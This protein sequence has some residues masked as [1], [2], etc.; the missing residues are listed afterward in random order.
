MALYAEAK[1]Q[2]R[3]APAGQFQ[4]VCCEVLDLGFNTR[5]YKNKQTGGEDVVTNHEIQF[6]FQLNKIDD[7]TGKRFEIRSAPLN[8]ILSEKANLRKFLMSWRGHDLTDEEKR[9]P[10]LDVEKLVGRNAIIS[11]VHNPV[12]DKT[13]ANI[14]SVMPLMEGMPEIVPEN[15]QPKQGYIDQAANGQAAAAPAQAA[16]TAPASLPSQPLVPQGRGE[17]IDPKEI[18]F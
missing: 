12:G 1:E 5:T 6:V 13:Y 10:G 7:E 3:K 8:L 11:I 15:Y 18:P 4:A 16:A 2:Y 17:Q 14:A 9:P